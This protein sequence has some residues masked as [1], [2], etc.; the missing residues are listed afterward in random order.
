MI[1]LSTFPPV[2]PFARRKLLG[3]AAVLPA[4]AILTA[5][6]PVTTAPPAVAAPATEE[7]IDEKLGDL[8]TIE[9]LTHGT[10]LDTA[11]D[12]SSPLFVAPFPC[13]IL[14][15]ALLV[16][17]LAGPLQ[18]TSDTDF[19]D[20]Q[21][22]RFRDASPVIVA[23]KTTRHSAG[24]DLPAGEAIS[25]RVPWTFDAAVFDKSARV[26]QANDALDVAFVATGSPVALGR[27]LYAQV[28][29]RPL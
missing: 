3:R 21:L 4:S 11:V 5:S 26:L 20:V 6:V 28:R 29:Y 12:G 19:W 9:E 16:G 22:R 25:H 8:A 17:R 18:P 13:E 23:R 1:G 27:P 7:L 10:L 15:A 2:A 24:P 14:W